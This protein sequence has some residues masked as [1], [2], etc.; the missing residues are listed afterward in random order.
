VQAGFFVPPGL[1]TE[2]FIQ[3]GWDTTSATFARVQLRNGSGDWSVASRAAALAA[4]FETAAVHFDHLRVEL[5]V[6]A[7]DTRTFIFLAKF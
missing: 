3:A 4:S 1:D 2:V 7:T 6:A 5:G